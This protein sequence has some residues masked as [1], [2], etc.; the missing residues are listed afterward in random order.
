M[1]YLF[2]NTELTNFFFLQ[3]VYV[4]RDLANI[5]VFF[6]KTDS[7]PALLYLSSLN[8]SLSRS[9]MATYEVHHKNFH[10]ISPEDSIQ[11]GRN[12]LGEG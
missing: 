3:E 1:S 8:K 6:S 12:G 2:N 5:S 7:L 11:W 10:L 9:L 4:N